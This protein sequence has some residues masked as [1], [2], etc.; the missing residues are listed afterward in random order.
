MIP[1]RGFMRSSPFSNKS[2]SFLKF[3]FRSFLKKNLYTIFSLYM[4]KRLPL[5]ASCIY[6][7]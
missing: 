1:D 7:G 4:Y 6:E 2:S 5:C 3:I